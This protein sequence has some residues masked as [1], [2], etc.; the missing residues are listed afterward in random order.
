[1]TALRACQELL[2][3]GDVAT[4]L[5]CSVACVRWYRAEGELPAFYLGTQPVFRRQDVDRLRLTPP[6]PQP[7]VAPQPAFGQG[8]RRDRIVHPLLED[9]A[10]GGE[11][12]SRGGR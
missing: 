1:M 12:C 6:T 11:T 2:S 10:V 5:G 4:I 3:I 7:S 8:A 9:T